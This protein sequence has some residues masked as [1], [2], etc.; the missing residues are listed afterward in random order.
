MGFNSCGLAAK[1]MQKGRKQSQWGQKGAKRNS[2]AGKV[3]EI[4]SNLGG[5]CIKEPPG[6]SWS[7]GVGWWSPVLYAWHLPCQRAAAHG[8]A[9]FCP[10]ST[11]LVSKA[12]C[13]RW[14]AGQGTGT[15]VSSPYSH[16]PPLVVTGE[17]VGFLHG[18]QCPVHQ[19]GVRLEEVGE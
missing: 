11:G 5:G 18:A 12:S 15:K 9:L 8:Q 17:R 7:T 6:R 2:K 16:T 4:K 13:Q 19:Q 3:R 10:P 1:E 14:E